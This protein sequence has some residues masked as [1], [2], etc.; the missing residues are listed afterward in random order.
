MHI[1]IITHARDQLFRRAP[2][3]R[4]ISDYMLGPI[5]H[6][7]AEKGH[8]VTVRQGTA[9]PPEA[10]DFALLHVD[11]TLVPP[12]YLAFAASRA[13]CLNIKVTDISKRAV[14]GAV[15]RDGVDWEGPVIVKSDLN[16][17]GLREGSDYGY[18]IFDSR[19][20][21]P[22]GI[23]SDPAL[24]VE[25]FLPERVD[26][27]YAVRFWTFAGDAERCSRV[28]SNDPIVKASNQ[29]G[30]EFVD[31]PQKLREIRAAL[32]FD[33]GK[34]DFV[35]HE[36]EPVLIDANKTPGAPP[37]PKAATWPQDYADGLLRI[38]LAAT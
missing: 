7:L 17:Q 5:V 8:S 26:G 3:G 35:M 4:M 2:D 6:Q 13:P 38:G 1:L 10:A 31:V 33:Y 15:L 19:R 32:G 29:T 12:D 37:V 20:A 25:R 28:F 11:L 16:F 9:Q 34:F 24:V 36:G 21:L 23:A 27:G 18:R 22:R 14:S 30:F